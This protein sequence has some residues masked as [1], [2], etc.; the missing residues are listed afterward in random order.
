[1]GTDLNQEPNDE[2]FG[3]DNVVLR[4]RNIAITSEVFCAA[5]DTNYANGLP[6]MSIFD[7]KVTAN[8][9]IIPNSEMNMQCKDKRFC[10]QQDDSRKCTYLMLPP[11]IYWHTI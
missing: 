8:D 5:P 2:S 10:R 3:I 11:K 4:H 7:F 6:K 9:G 1:M